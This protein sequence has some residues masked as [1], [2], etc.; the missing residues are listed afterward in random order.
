MSEETDQSMWFDEAEGRLDAVGAQGEARL[1][2]V[3]YI[4]WMRPPREKVSIDYYVPTLALKE[5]SKTSMV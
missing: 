3:H 2:D 5:E 1:A 4:D